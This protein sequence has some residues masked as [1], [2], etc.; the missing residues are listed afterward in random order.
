MGD[1]M[2]TELEASFQLIFSIIY[3]QGREDEESAMVKAV[4]TSLTA[5]KSQVPRRRLSVLVVLFNLIYKVES[6]VDILLGKPPPF[7]VTDCPMLLPD[8]VISGQLSSTTRLQ[9]V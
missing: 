8:C 1:G 6:K 2:A 7:R 9:R 5:N 3:L 4:I